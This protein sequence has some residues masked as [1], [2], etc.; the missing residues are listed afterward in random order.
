[1]VAGAADVVVRRVR[2]ALQE[3]RQQGLP[4]AEQRRE[5]LPIRAP[6]LARD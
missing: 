5:A 2:Q 4:H 3:R 1:L 6:Q